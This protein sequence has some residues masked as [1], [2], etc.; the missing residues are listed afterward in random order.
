MERHGMARNKA[1]TL[2]EVELEFMHVIWA[3]DEVTTEDVRAAL[4]SNGRSLTDGSVRKVLSI[5]VDKGYVKRRRQ[6]RGF[7]YRAVVPQERASRSMVADL[8]KRAFDGSAAQMVAAL[9][10]TRAVDSKELQKIKQLIADHE[11]GG[12]AS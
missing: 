1:R 9:L 12:Q 6:A 11:E 2:T 4:A 8:L 10:G 7:L 5:L 3:A